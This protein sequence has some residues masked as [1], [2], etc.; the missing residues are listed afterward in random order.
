[1]RALIFANP[2]IDVQAAV[3]QSND[4]GQREGLS[5]APH[6]G[7]VRRSHAIH[8]LERSR[9]SRRQVCVLVAEK[10]RLTG[11]VV[12]VDEQREALASRLSIRG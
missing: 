5:A 6:I 8:R 11:T 10:R 4:P 1:M 9:E 7:R 3:V 12:D 2:L